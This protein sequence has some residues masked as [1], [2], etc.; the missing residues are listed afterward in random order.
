MPIHNGETDEYSRRNR[1]RIGSFGAH[2][3]DDDLDRRRPSIQM[4][5]DE[6]QKMQLILVDMETKLDEK[7]KEVE[8]LTQS[9]H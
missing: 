7:I 1:N 6:V 2:D 8:K 5:Q 3:P 4:E 9:R